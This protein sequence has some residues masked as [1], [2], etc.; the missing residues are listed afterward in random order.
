MVDFY[1]IGK[2]V[3]SSCPDGL[4]GHWRLIMITSSLCVYELC[5]L[6]NS[7]LTLVADANRFGIFST[8]SEAFTVRSSELSSQ[9]FIVPGGAFFRSMNCDGFGFN[10]VRF[11]VCFTK[12]IVKRETY[13][14]RVSVLK[15][16]R[17]QATQCQGRVRLKLRTTSGLPHQND[18]HV[19]LELCFWG[20]WS[21]GF[22][23]CVMSGLRLKKCFSAEDLL[24]EWNVRDSQTKTYTSGIWTQ[25]YDSLE[26]S[27][28]AGQ[29]SHLSY[30]RSS[31]PIESNPS[32][33][34][35]GNLI[36][37]FRF[38]KCSAKTSR[39]TERPVLGWVTNNFG[40][41]CDR[42]GLSCD[43]SG[44]SCD[45]SGLSCER[46][47]L[48]CDRFGISCARSGLSC[49]RSGLSYTDTLLPVL[50]SHTASTHTAA[51]PRP[52][53]LPAPRDETQGIPAEGEVLRENQKNDNEPE[54]S[55]TRLQALKY[56][57]IS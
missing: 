55:T 14:R 29:E 43:R 4:V 51:D 3:S 10:W 37:S 20:F 32:E 56:V 23:N 16:T 15:D 30:W 31:F 46:F 25:R 35:Q 40:L 42:F 5:W 54:K 21:F 12:G 48:S 38:H 45:R 36:Y 57:P 28:S 47:G 13:L 17:M 1:L 26:S 22:I 2:S 39:R 53:Q 44:L 41:S 34:L 9:A 8:Y 19:L 49:D 33:S 27:S 18:L 50:L 11:E 6:Q 24:K 52:D 7:P